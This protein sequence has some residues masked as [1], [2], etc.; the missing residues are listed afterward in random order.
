M[1]IFCVKY[2]NIGQYK[3]LFRALKLLVD[4]IPAKSLRLRLVIIALV[5]LILCS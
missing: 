2:F 4:V 1:T 3:A 5:I